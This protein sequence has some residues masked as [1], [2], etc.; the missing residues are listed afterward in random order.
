MKASFKEIK[1]LLCAM[2]SNVI[3]VYVV[4]MCAS[5]SNTHCISHTTYCIY[6]FCGIIYILLKDVRNYI[7]FVKLFKDLFFRIKDYGNICLCLFL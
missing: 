5:C 6:L 7:I 1:S 3:R 2:C 4:L